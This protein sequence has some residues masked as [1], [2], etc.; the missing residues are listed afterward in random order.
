MGAEFAGLNDDDP[1]RDTTSVKHDRTFGVLGRAEQHGI[2]ARP[3][4]NG[5]VENRLPNSRKHPLFSPF[6]MNALES[7]LWSMHE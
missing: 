2:P 5:S 7:R 6:R 1:R 4:R 3:D